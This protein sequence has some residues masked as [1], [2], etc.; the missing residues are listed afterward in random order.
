M[1]AEKTTRLPSYFLESAEF[2]ASPFLLWVDSSRISFRSKSTRRTRIH[3]IS[4]ER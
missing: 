2:L 1:P 3:L 4:P